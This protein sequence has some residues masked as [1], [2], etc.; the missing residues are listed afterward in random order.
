[1]A[2]GKLGK[3][4]PDAILDKDRKY[5]Y[6]LKRQW[7]QRSDNFANFV[8]LNPSTANESVDDPTVKACMKIAHNLGFDGIY[9]TNLFAFRTKNPEILKRSKDPVGNQNNK[10][11]EEYAHKAKL[12]IVAW[13]NYG[14]LLNRDGD[15][16]KIL[17][18][19]KIPQCLAY[20]KLGYPKHP[21]Y[22]NRKIEPFKFKISSTLSNIAR[23]TTI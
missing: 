20:T 5:R 2:N 9:I 10:Y 18:K 12:V 8:L 11:I 19:T 21:L 17:S 22:I 4:V 13:G 7:G 1:M 14:N 3:I 16:L 15:V 23:A 6:T